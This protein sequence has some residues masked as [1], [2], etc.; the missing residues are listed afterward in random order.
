MR[1]D[2]EAALGRMRGEQAKGKGTLAHSESGVILAARVTATTAA[3]AATAEDVLRATGAESIE[4]VEGDWQDGEWRDFDP[5]RRP[6]GTTQGRP[7]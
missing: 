7:R 3:T 1:I 5:V 2:V 4:R 6:D